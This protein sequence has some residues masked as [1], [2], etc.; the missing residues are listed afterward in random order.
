MNKHEYISSG[1][2]EAYALGELSEPERREVEHHLAGHPE[3]RTEL[4]QIEAVQ[5][6]LLQRTAITPRNAVKAALFAR[7]DG[8]PPAA[9]G[10][11]MPSSEARM[12]KFA[13]AASVTVALVSSYLAYNY[14]DKWKRTQGELTERI[15][16][17]QRVASDYNQVNQR[18]DKIERDIHIIQNPA[19]KRVALKGTS[20]APASLAYVYWNEDTREVYL[21]VHELQHLTRENQY[22]LWA[23][24]DGKPVDAG[25][26]DGGDAG[27]LLKM[28]EIGRGAT[29]FA[30]TV[31]PRGGKPAP[32]LETMQ[33]AGPVEKG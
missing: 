7:I 10:V 26:F 17:S 6:K 2:L 13:A 31:E 1:I 15:A 21:S 12:W 8:Q 30:V 18:L 24:I 20:H 16:Q 33:V 5:E 9:K 3:L 19:F 11:S 14:Y 29:L 22:Q 4:D 25:V 27:E 23:I 32:T 28:K